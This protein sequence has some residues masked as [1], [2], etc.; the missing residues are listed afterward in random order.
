MNNPEK[1]LGN[2][3]GSRGD[4][5][6]IGDPIRVSKADE[7]TD[8]FNDLKDSI[9]SALVGLNASLRSDPP[10]NKEPCTL[11]E[12]YEGNSRSLQYFL[13]HGP[14]QMREFQVRALDLIQ[15][16]KSRII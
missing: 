7:V 14:D 6:A 8:A 11:P 10:E 9:E 1:I 5:A 3:Y 12:C 4:Q 13:D 15:E 16:I 2:G